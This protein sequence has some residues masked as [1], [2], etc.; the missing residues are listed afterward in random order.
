MSIVAPDSRAPVASNRATCDHGRKIRRRSVATT[1]PVTGGIAIADGDDEVV[2]LAQR[3][4]VRVEHGSADGLAQVEHGVP[5]RER[6]VPPGWRDHE[7]RGQPSGG[8]TD[9]VPGDDAAAG[10]DGTRTVVHGEY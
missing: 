4:V 2:D 9:L 3:L 8:G 6:D 5:P 1:S 7:G 10:A